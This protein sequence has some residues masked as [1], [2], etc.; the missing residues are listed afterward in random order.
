M[1][2]RIFLRAI[3]LGLALMLVGCSDGGAVAQ[4]T[5]LRIASPDVQE[6][7]LSTLSAGNQQFS[8]DL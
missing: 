1:E 3:I 4:S 5:K 8:F 7:D 2:N 6:T